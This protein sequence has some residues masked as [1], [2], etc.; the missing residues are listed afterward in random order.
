MSL[1]ESSGSE[2]RGGENFERRIKR[3]WQLQNIEYKGEGELRTAK[4]I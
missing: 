4:S 2:I 3:T 1:N